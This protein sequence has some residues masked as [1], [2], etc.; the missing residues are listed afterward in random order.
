MSSC[1]AETGGTT[2]SPQYVDCAAQPTGKVGTNLDIDK[3]GD[4]VVLGDQVHKKTFTV[5]VEKTHNYIDGTTTNKVGVS[6]TDENPIPGGPPDVSLAD[7]NAVP[8]KTILFFGS[9]DTKPYWNLSVTAT[10]GSVVLAH[11]DCRGQL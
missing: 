9:G 3:P 11:F 4:R 2:Y 7:L 10:G 6:G 8:D 5:A 1:N